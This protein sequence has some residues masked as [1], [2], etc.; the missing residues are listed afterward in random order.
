MEIFIIIILGLRDGFKIKK[1]RRYIGKNKSEAYD[2]SQF[3]LSMREIGEKELSLIPRNYTDYLLTYSKKV[4][5]DI[6][7]NNILISNLR[8]FFPEINLQIEKEFPIEF[9]YNSNNIEGSKIPFEEVKKIVLFQKSRY[10]DKEEIEGAKNSIKAYNFIKNNFKFNMK[11]IKELHR[12]LTNNLH[13]ENGVFYHQ[14]FKE[15]EIVV[16]K[17]EMETIYP[18]EVKQ[19]LKELIE[20]YKEKK[21]TLF[22]PELAFKFYFKY[23][24]IH[25]FEDGNGRT[26]RLI[27]N[28]IL[29]DGKFQPMIIYKKNKNSHLKAF[30]RGRTGNIKNFLDFMFKRYR[31]NYKEFYSK[32]IK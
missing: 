24:K 19:E 23:E 4:I 27:M 21:K 16:G 13:D 28:K 3:K 9:I 25:P 31:A 5:E 7:K 26:G 22:P 1:I 6:F 29:M 2:I 18:T 8:E 14:G 15:R 32:F 11:S 10:K 12:I 30:E 17:M 20:W